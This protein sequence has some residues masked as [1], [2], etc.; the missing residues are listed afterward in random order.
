M[1]KSQD[2]IHTLETEESSVHCVAC[3]HACHCGDTC[4]DNSC[5]CGVCVHNPEE[6]E[7]NHRI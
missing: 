4:S 3:G 6:L 1:K 7:D 5:Y 2:L